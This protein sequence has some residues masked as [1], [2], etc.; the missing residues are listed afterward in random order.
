MSIGI[1]P[2]ADRIIIQTDPAE[3]VTPGGIYIPIT[4]QEKPL[5]GTVV[6]AGKGRYIDGQEPIPM[7]VSEGDRVIYGRNVGTELTWMGNDYL[8]MRDVDVFA[9]I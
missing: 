7:S 9:I 8:I 3:T 6:A 1:K 5:I 2:I 4:A